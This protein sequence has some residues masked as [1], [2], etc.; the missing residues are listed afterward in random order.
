MPPV[1]S[2]SVLTVI[3][4]GQPGRNPAHKHEDGGAE[5][6]AS[7]AFPTLVQLPERLEDVPR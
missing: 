7:A 6:F 3:P 4:L 5:W 2:A 1:V